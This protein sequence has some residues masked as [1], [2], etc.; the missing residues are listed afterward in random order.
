M[1]PSGQTGVVMLIIFSFCL[2]SLV[3]LLEIPLVVHFPTAADPRVILVAVV[4]YPIASKSDLSIS[5][6]GNAGNS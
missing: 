1:I 2:G 4:P 3:Y 6:V 5:N